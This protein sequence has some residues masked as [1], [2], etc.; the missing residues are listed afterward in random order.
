M[1]KTLSIILIVI[2]LSGCGYFNVKRHVIMPDGAIYTVDALK[3]DT[4]SFKNKDVDFKV[5]GKPAP[6]LFEKVMAFL[7]MNFPDMTLVK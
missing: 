1:Y 4:V 3:E 6:G 5:D 2:M 7:F